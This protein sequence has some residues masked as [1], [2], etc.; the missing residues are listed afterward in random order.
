MAGLTKNNVSLFYSVREPSRD[1]STA[2][3]S[4]NVVVSNSIKKVVLTIGSAVVL[5]EEMS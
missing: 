4:V 2:K 5:V 3:Q 1:F